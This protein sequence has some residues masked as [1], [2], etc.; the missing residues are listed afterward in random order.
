MI[1]GKELTKYRDLIF[2]SKYRLYCCKE[3]LNATKPVR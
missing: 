3:A 1:I 2:S